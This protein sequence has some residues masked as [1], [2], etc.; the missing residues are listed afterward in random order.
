MEEEKRPR[1]RPKGT[2][3]DDLDRLY[4][5]GKLIGDEPDLRPTT[6]I[7]RLG[8]KDPSTVRRLRDK[9]NAKRDMIMR[10]I[11][12]LEVT[13][14]LNDN[15]AFRLP[16]EAARQALK[17]ASGV[18]RRFPKDVIATPRRPAEQRSEISCLLAIGAHA[19]AQAAAR[20]S[21]PLDVL[22]IDRSDE[23]Q[24]F[25]ARMLLMISEPPKGDETPAT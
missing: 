1:G 17:S 19:L 18:G 14:K 5:I 10:E 24:V 12:G 8:Y 13:T 25:L 2:G 15:T 4:A 9:F 3:I 16:T 11:T 22:D 21:D 7:K 20:C 23:S 6:A